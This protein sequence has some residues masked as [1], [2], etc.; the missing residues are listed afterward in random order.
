MLFFGDKVFWPAIV[1]IVAIGWA[2]AICFGMFISAELADRLPSPGLSM[3]VQMS[4]VHEFGTFVGLLFWL[5]GSL[6]GF[7]NESELQFIAAFVSVALIIAA[8]LL[9]NEPD[10]ATVW[11]LVITDLSVSVD[12]LLARKIASIAVRSQLTAREQD[13]LVLLAKGRNAEHIAGELVISLYTAK[14]HIQR[15]Y[16]KLDVHSQ[17]EVIDLVE[18]QN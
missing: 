2:L 3:F 13:V 9:L 16:F 5:V 8:I 7:V 14:T 4:S 12:D 15:I 6:T 11:G 18:S 1:L 10:K 17:Q